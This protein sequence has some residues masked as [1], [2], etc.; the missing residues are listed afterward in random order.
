MGILNEILTTAALLIVLPILFWFISS[1]INTVKSKMDDEKK[2]SFELS[3]NKFKNAIIIILGLL[4]LLGFIDIYNEITVAE[5][6]YIHLLG[7]FK[8]AKINKGYINTMYVFSVCQLILTF[9]VLLCLLI[10]SN[11]KKIIM[12]ICCMIVF[13]LSIGIKL[14]EVYIFYKEA[15]KYNYINDYDIKADFERD[16]KISE[17]GALK[18]IKNEFEFDYINNIVSEEAN[19]EEIED[20]TIKYSC[21]YENFWIISF[22]YMKNFEITRNVCAL[23]DFE[24]GQVSFLTISENN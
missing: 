4:C 8:Y 10:K 7:V 19:I 18:A 23:V 21:D 16:G 17:S 11:K 14:K 1:Y 5:N 13:A 12:I 2:N 15:E 20:E 24:T 22:D 9:E 6:S 3:I